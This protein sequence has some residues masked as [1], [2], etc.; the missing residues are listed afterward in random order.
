MK[1]AIYGALLMF[2]ASAAAAAD[3]PPAPVARVEAVTDTYFGETITDRYRWMENDKDPDWLPFLKQQNAHARAILDTLPKRDELLKRIQQLS[4]DIAAPEDVQR[5]GARVFYQQRPAGSNNFKLFVREGGKDRVLVDPTRLDTESGH[6]SLDW[7]RAS[8]DGSKLVYGLSKDGS[9]DSV[10]HIMDVRT[11][12]VLKERIADTQAANPSWLA[13][14]SGFF[15]NQLTGKVNTPDRYLDAQARFHKLGTNPAQDPVLMKRGLD[16]AI[17]YANIQSPYIGVAPHSDHAYLMLSDVRKEFRLYTAPLKDV[18]KGKANWRQVSDFADEVTDFNLHGDDLYLLSTKDH[19]RGRL[20]KTSAK[21]PSLASAKE[22]VPESSLVLQ[23]VTRAKDG[24]Y[25]RSMDGGVSKLQ[26]LGADGKLVDIALPFDGTLIALATDA[27]VPGALSILSGWLQPTGIWSIDNAGKVADTGITP[28][29][30]LDLSAYTTERRYAVAKDGTQ[31]PYSLIYKKG[32]K[33][34]GKNP[35]FISAYGSYGASAYTPE[36]GSRKL[37][38]LDQ[39]GIVGYANVRGG[40]E[41]GREWHRAG[42]LEN[43]PNTWRDLIAVCEDMQAKG[44][45]SPAYQAIGGRSAGGITMGR[46][47]EERP[48]LFAAV[49]SGVGWHNPLRYVAEQNGYGEEPEWGA[50]ADPAGF[51]AL[52]SIDSYQQVVDGAKYPAVLLTTGV[53]DP[54]VAPFH[55]A[56]MAARLQAATASGKPV[57]LRVDFDAGHGMGST[58]AQQDAETADTYAF[59]LSQVGK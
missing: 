45:T 21:A 10:L 51:K 31:I 4:G 38:F 32:L 5:A 28:K 1:P 8:P 7:W 43:K 53:T 49:V 14:S 42:Q 37:A 33:L 3:I 6:V 11:G 12:A 57:L 9:E 27:S 24:L 23:G 20:L 54:R 22:V 50:I 36:F 59:I 13:D 56:K 30:A 58:R 52:K 55:P 2:A 25:L 39:G 34:D 35:A 44:Y 40:G 29:P 41:F 19:S 18:L 16:A 46:A 15:Y 17:Q 47:L 48:D 26:R